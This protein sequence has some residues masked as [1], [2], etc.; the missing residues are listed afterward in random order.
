MIFFDDGCVEYIYHKDIRLIVHKTIKEVWNDV[1]PGLRKEFLQNYLEKYPERQMVKLTEQDSIRANFK[2]RWVVAKV[3][4]VD[5]SLVKLYFIESKVYEWLYRGSYRLYKMYEKQSKS[6]KGIRLRQ[7]GLA[8]LNK[9]IIEFTSAEESESKCVARKSTTK[10]S[11]S[12]QSDK[13]PKRISN[14][15]YLYD[16]IKLEVP[17]TAP[18]SKKY[19]PHECNKLCVEWTA[20]DYNKTKRISMLAIPLY[21][22]F[23]R[24]LVYFNRTQKCVV[25]K[26][27]CGRL[28]RSMKEMFNYLIETKSKMTIDQFDFNSWV[29]PQAEFRVLKSKKFLND[30]SAGKEFRGITC[31]N[32]ID[33][34]LPPPMVYMTS[35]QAMPGVNINV[36]S[37]FLCGCDCT[38]NCQDKS[39]CA[40]WQMTIEGQKIL[41]N[42]YKDP[43][44]GYNY[45]RLPERVLTGIY[46]CNK[47]CKCSSSCLNRVVQ[48]PLSQK[49]QL[50]L[51]EKKGWGVRCI[52]DI[53][54]GSFICI[55]V[56]Y[57]L[58]ETDANE[59]GINYGDEYLAELDYI[60]VVEKIKEDYE[61]EVSL[62]DEENSDSYETDESSGM[63]N[64]SD[65]NY[66]S[67]SE[68]NNY[69]I[70]YDS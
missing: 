69:L 9:P 56:G 30:L 38:D 45:R 32:V 4:K 61:S 15:N 18:L 64:S 21:F 52:N 53:P 3:I 2:N 8:Y 41:P 55:Y 14:T 59:G 47:T 24:S 60:E 50:F 67:T 29:R 70:I 33:N 42:L 44:I 13:S 68:G 1:G 54:Q 6:V 51:T 63:T 10:C 5:A 19:I 28:I 65:E 17:K 31:V 36:D 40:C 35:R 57:L 62:S 37:D 34:K 39:K 16:T 7:S 66:Q 12:S 25:Y 27:P 26:T 46:E 48:F 58:T 49:L 11:T 23:N 20:Y 43:D 22:G